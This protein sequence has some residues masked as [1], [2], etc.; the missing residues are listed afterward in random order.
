M[1]YQDLKE[2]IKSWFLIKN[3]DKERLMQLREL[4]K[5]FFKKQKRPSNLLP[6]QETQ[7]ASDILN[8]ESIFTRYD[9]LLETQLLNFLGL[10][11]EPSFDELVN[12]QNDEENTNFITTSYIKK[13]A[14][15]QKKYIYE[16]W[17]GNRKYVDI[18]LFNKSDIYFTINK[19]VDFN[20]EMDVLKECFECSNEIS[21]LFFT[22]KKVR[23]T[24]SNEL[25]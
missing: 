17:S 4:T 19:A 22:A 24:K 25:K 3:I 2:F 20:L 15:Y 21:N 1:K 16:N 8:K 18:H 23:E 7:L 10:S 5:Y 14:K 6:Y 11:R 9:H 13:L 12:D